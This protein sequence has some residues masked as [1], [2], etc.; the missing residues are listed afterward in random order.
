MNSD[1]DADEK[2]RVERASRL[3]AQIDELKKASSKK[4]D[5][6]G[7][8]SSDAPKSPRNFIHERMAELA[9]GKKDN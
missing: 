5:E 8:R 7:E 6:P 1:H 2:A 9:K 3:H 4:S